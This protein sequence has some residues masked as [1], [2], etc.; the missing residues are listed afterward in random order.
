[1]IKFAPAVEGAKGEDAPLLIYVPGID[2][3]GVT[4]VAQFPELASA[5]E[6]QCLSFEGRDRS[7][8]ADIKNNVKARVREAKEKG[9]EVYLMG[10]SF[11]GIV[12]LS[13]GMDDS[14]A[15]LMPDRLIVVNAA[16]SFDRTLLG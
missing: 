6:L 11:G 8:F 14:E 5:F 9:R 10:E 13:I 16:T 12:A 3:T 7:T 4:P 1:M 2:G 15:S